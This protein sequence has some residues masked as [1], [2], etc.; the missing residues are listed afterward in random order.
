M[1]GFEEGVA[2]GS[3]FGVDVR[4]LGI[5]GAIGEYGEDEIIGVVKE[6]AVGDLVELFFKGGVDKLVQVE[7]GFDCAGFGFSRR[8]C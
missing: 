7:C 2:G 8:T 1:V 3:L 6:T 5:E 4:H